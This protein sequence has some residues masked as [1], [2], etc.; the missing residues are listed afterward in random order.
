MQIFDFRLPGDCRKGHFGEFSRPLERILA[1]DQAR[2]RKTLTASNMLR[3]Q[4][5]DGF[6]IDPWSDSGH[7]A[8]AIAV[9]REKLTAEKDAK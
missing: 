5:G 9:C 8:R 4:L 2:E 6:E 1:G 7:P 3:K